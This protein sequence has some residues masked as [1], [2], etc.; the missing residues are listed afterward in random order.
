MALGE[1]R[2]IIVSGGDQMIKVT[3]PTSAKS[4][5][6]QHNIEALTAVGPFK[7]IV[8]KNGQDQV[9]FSRPATGDWSITIE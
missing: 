1:D 5:G 9:E 3:L 8:V 4:I 7:T 2:P 6:G